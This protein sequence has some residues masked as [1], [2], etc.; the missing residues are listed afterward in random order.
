MTTLKD[1]DKALFKFK[2]NLLETF[3]RITLSRVNLNQANFHKK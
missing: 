1:P 3:A 2:N